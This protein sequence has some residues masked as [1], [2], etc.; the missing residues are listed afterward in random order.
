M[1]TDILFDDIGLFNGV[2][3]MKHSKLNINITSLE[4]NKLSPR[5]DIEPIF[6]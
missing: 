4:L 1:N 5:F 3:W 6:P 2:S